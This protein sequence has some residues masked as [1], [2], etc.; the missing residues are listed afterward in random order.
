MPRFAR[1]RADTVRRGLIAINKQFASR[2][3]AKG[4]SELAPV[5]CNDS[6]SGQEF[7]RRVEVWIR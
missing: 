6:L 7:N 5:A 3:E 1:S 2:I 4:Y